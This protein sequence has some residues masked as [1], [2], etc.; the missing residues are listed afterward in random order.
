[1]SLVTSGN[2]GPSLDS[3]KYIMGELTVAEFTVKIK[4]GKK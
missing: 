4:D 1:M 3:K 2:H